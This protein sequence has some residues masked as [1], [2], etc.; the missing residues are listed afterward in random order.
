[1]GSNPAGLTKQ[2]PLKLK[3]SRGFAIVLVAI[4]KGYFAELT[5]VSQSKCQS[6]SQG[7]FIPL[8]PKVINQIGVYLNIV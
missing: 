8:Q 5:E 7:I 2:C 4:L 1:M 3:V 6:V